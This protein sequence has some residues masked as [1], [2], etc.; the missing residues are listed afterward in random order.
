MPRLVPVLLA[1]TVAAPF[2]SLGAEPKEECAR[3]KAKEGCYWALDQHANKCKR[4]CI[5][6]QAPIPAGVNIPTNPGSNGY[7]GTSG[8]GNSTGY[9]VPNKLDATPPVGTSGGAH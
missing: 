1:L 9:T 8:G 3:K 7:V 2:F 4:H 5:V 6:L